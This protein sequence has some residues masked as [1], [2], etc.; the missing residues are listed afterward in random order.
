M[1]TG[2]RPITSRRGRR[3]DGN[4]ALRDTIKLRAIYRSRCER[5]IS[6]ESAGVPINVVRTSDT[7]TTCD[8]ESGRK[9][10]TFLFW[11]HLGTVGRNCFDAISKG[12]DHVFRCFLRWFWTST[13]LLW[14]ISKECI[15]LIIECKHYDAFDN[16][17]VCSLNPA[18]HLIP[19]VTNTKRK[20]KSGFHKVIPCGPLALKSDVK[21][22]KL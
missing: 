11:V 3:V 22:T 10:T 21:Y 2:G 8:Y 18:W 4:N 1:S 5:E 17:C 16:D 14:L 13:A 6:A 12:S 9:V 7:S 20:L 19:K 15:L